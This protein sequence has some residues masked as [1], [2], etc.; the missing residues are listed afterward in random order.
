ME[1]QHRRPSSANH[2]SAHQGACWEVLSQ[3][4]LR[5]MVLADHLHLTVV[6]DLHEA[7]RRARLRQRQRT[8][9]PQSKNREIGDFDLSQEQVMSLVSQSTCCEA[10]VVQWSAVA[11]YVMLVFGITPLTVPHCTILAILGHTIADDMVCRTASFHGAKH[12]FEPRAHVERCRR[13]MHPLG[14]HLPVTEGLRKQ[15]QRKFLM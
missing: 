14:V 1:E 9:S 4:D 15:M 10:V 11:F 2:K 13:D 3:G 6:R 12:R 7:G 8:P 5:D